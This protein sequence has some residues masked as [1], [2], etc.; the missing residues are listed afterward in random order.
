[1]ASHQLSTDIIMEDPDHHKTIDRKENLFDEVFNQLNDFQKNVF[2]E[3]IKHKKAGLSLPL[4]SGKTILSIMLA[5]YFTDIKKTKTKTNKRILIVVSK[6]LLQSWEIEIEKFFGKDGLPFEVLHTDTVKNLSAWKPKNN[7]KIILTTADVIGRCY[8]KV[9][10]KQQFIDQV[11]MIR[12]PGIYQ[13]V[14]RRPL[15]PFLSHQI[16]HGIL[17][18]ETWGC[19]IIDEIQKYTNI[20]TQWCQGLGAICSRYR[21]GLSG[22]IFDEPKVNNVLGFCVIL[23]LNN[24]PRCIPEMQ[25]LLYSSK[26]KGLNQYLVSRKKNE[27]FIPPRINEHVIT[28][29]LKEEERIV[30]E[31]LKHALTRIAK[32]TKDAE[33]H[34]NHEE[35]RMLNSQKLTMILYLRETLVCPML[36]IASVVV[37]ACDFKNRAPLAK[38]ILNELSHLELDDWINDEK[39]VMSSRMEELIKCIEKH[40]SE[41]V[42]LYACF[43]AFLS[44]MEYFLQKL[45]NDTTNKREIFLLKASM[46]IAKRKELLEDFKQSKNGILLVSYHLGAEGL[47]LQFASTVLLTDFWWNASK[48]Q[49]AIGR[50]FRFGQIRD[51]I[52]VY[53]FTSN[54]GIEKILFM[55]QKAKLALVE[56]M[57]TGKVKSKIPRINM[58]EVIRLISMAEN[59]D[60]LRDIRFY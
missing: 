41:K 57:K 34:R 54:T 26:F 24:Q 46:S 28:H 7:S 49:Q 15:Q 16:G 40:S 20:E 5:L 9:E 17:F 21:W 27:G 44:L 45:Y 14:Y 56:E 43:P 22:T 18:S 60:L 36:P 4:G 38:L 37:A 3:C 48:I 39:S 47:N 11:Y 6:T 19:L 55:K 29:T 35:L 51:E 13:N 25:S 33:I 23:D 1:M 42:I 52:N 53:F 12:Y 58:K 2:Y 31:T 10:L 50:I 59:E 8:R 30:Y 32:D